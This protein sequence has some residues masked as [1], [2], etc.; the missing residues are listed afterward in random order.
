MSYVMEWYNIYVFFLS[1]K[2]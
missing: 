1:L 2:Y